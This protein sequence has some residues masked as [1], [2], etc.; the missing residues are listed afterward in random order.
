MAHVLLLN[1]TCNGDTLEDVSEIA[2]LL[3]AA[4][5]H[6]IAQIGGLGQPGGDPLRIA[7]QIGDA[8]DDASADLQ[9][10]AGTGSCVNGSLRLTRKLAGQKQENS[11]RMGQPA[12]L[13][14]LGDGGGG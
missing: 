9:A 4:V 3:L 11:R 8:G 7:H 10:I 6:T 13:H 14:G 12:P 5:G 1:A 2:T